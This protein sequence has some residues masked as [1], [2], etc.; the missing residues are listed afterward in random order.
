[1]TER[2]LRWQKKTIKQL[3]SEK[4]VLL[5]S[6]PRQSGK[7]NLARESISSIVAS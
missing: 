7:T 3:M 5:L 6:G 2:Y 4:R 1:M